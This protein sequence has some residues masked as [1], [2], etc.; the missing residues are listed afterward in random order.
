MI[1]NI[2]FTLRQMRKHPGFAA[3]AIVTLA[4]GIGANTAM[5][6][7][8]DSVMLRPLPYPD[9]NS[10]MA[11]TPGSA[12]QGNTVQTTSWLN[13]LDLRQAR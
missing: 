3:L 7:V 13:Y 8:I 2:R 6:A 10:I 9:S 11:I 12:S 5:F 1:D 4:L